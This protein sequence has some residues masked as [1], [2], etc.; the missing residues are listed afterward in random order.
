M[1][2]TRIPAIVL[3]GGTGTRLHPLTAEHAK[4]ALPLAGGCRIVDFVLGN[5]FNSGIVSIYVLAQHKASWPVRPNVPDR[6]AGCL[7][8]SLA[9]AEQWHPV[10]TAC[11]SRGPRPG[12]PS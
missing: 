2:T 3:A 9:S 11:A 1:A 10:A 12:R 7:R 4:P 5:L 8:A 6:A